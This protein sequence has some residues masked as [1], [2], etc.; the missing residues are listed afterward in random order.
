MGKVLAIAGRI[1]G[2]V[3]NAGGTREGDWK[4]LEET[5]TEGFRGTL[6]LNLEYVF[7]VCRDFCNQVIKQGDGGA[8]VN[9]GSVSSIASAPFHG[10]YGAAK[11]GI[12]A[13]TRTMAFEWGKFGI[14]ANT[15]QPGMVP[16][17]RVMD[18]AAAGRSGQTGTTAKPDNSTV[19]TSIDEMAGAIIFLLSDWSSGVSGQTISIDS[20]MSTKFCGGAREFTVNKF[21]QAK[22]PA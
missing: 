3:N 17:K 12:A 9:V 7:R 5:T 20:A 1:D 15:V 14:R 13:L 4:S 8:I 19:P 22:I 11:A 18:R 21:S 6:N 10:P 2:V 16:S